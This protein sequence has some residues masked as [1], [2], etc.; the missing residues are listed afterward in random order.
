MR[1]SLQ[2]LKLQWRPALTMLVLGFSAGLPIL[3]IF[4][5]LSIWLREAGVEKSAVTYFSW[6][7]LGYSFKFVWAPL[8]DQ[9]ELPV[10]SR[11]LGR[12]RAWL[13]LSQAMVMAAIVAMAMIDPAQGGGLTTMA[14]AAVALGF[15]SATQDIVIDAF[16]IEVAEKEVQALLASTYIA[17][18]RLG[19]MIAGAFALYLAAWG[20]TTT[21]NYIYEAWRS[22]Y[23]FMAAF[24]LIGVAATLVVA[25]P[26]Y[27]VPATQRPLQEQLRFILLFA[28]MVAAF[29]VLYLFSGDVVSALKS[30]LKPG[31]RGGDAVVSTLVETVRLLAAFASAAVCAWC[32][33]KTKMV[34]LALVQQGYVSPVM[35]FFSRYGRSAWII[36]L[37][38]GFYKISDIVMG[39][40]ANIFY[41]DM[42]FDKEAIAS[43]TKV[44]GLWV[45]LFGGFAGGLWCLRYG[46]M[47]MLFVGAILTAGTNVLFMLLAG[48]EP[49][50]TGLALVICA[51][52]F[53]AGIASAAFIAFLSSLTNV[54][55]TAVQYALFS[56]LMTLFPKLLAGY[57]GSMVEELGYSNFFL[58]TALLGVPVLLLVFLAGRQLRAHE[59]S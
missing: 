59:N 52:N 2:L 1:E 42:G 9:L 26:R 10:L 27:S 44:F 57:S 28:L 8:V 22:S 14:L 55:F 7:A 12:R 4:S 16:R 18:Y 39:A 19:M 40:V 34:P 41:T 37:L 17:G 21:E 3:L 5:S 31:N 36:L 23:L 49:S 30:A 6:A 54:S 24:M 51:D 56:S 53:S 46:V 35:D 32:L 29:I 45:T 50:T 33:V 43:V 20:G 58:G 15:S 11:W 47:R 48:S 38:V 25:E 13:L